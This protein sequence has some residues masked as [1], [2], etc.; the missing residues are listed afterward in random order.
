METKRGRE[1]SD[2]EKY[3]EALE[4]ISKLVVYK[5]ITYIN[6]LSEIEAVCKKSLNPPPE[7]G[8]V[9]VVAWECTTCGCIQKN[10]P[11]KTCGNC[12]GPAFHDDF[13]KLTGTRLVPKKQKVKRREE[14]EIIGFDSNGKALINPTACMTSHDKFYHEWE[15]AAP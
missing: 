14:I 15:E 3:K 1:M 5:G 10:N 6:V 2:E 9:E 13:I 8:E 11:P 4:E 7:M 12:F